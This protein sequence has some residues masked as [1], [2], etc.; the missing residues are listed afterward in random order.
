MSDPSPADTPKTRYNTSQRAA[1]VYPLVPLGRHGQVE[2]VQDVVHLL[3][4]H[5]G[6]DTSGQEPVAGLERAALSLSR[7]G[8]NRLTEQP[9]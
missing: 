5:L 7:L 2:P 8:R 9:T 1:T 6:L 3:A 4:L